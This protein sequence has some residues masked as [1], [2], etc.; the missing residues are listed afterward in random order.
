[1]FWNIQSMKRHMLIARSARLTSKRHRENSLDLHLPSSDSRCHIYYLGH[2]QVLWPL[3]S[4]ETCYNHL[5]P[6]V[7]V[8]VSCAGLLPFAA[9][10]Q[11]SAVVCLSF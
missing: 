3:L 7:T 1:M 10:V 9:R 11:W 2:K 4:L 6:A 5:V 8:T